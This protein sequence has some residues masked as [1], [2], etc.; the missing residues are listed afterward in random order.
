MKK[1]MQVAKKVPLKKKAKA[2]TKT[3][4]K[5]QPKA[6]KEDK[7]KKYNGGTKKIAEKL[8]FIIWCGLSTKEKK[9]LQTQ[10]DFAKEF[11]VNIATLSKWK[12]TKGFWEAVAKHRNNR[13]KERVGDALESMFEKRIEK[14]G[15][16]TAVKIFLQA[17]GEFTEVT[18]D[19]SEDPMTPEKQKQI[20]DAVTKWKNK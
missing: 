4:V 6:T 8:D 10:N 12:N 18:K 3:K 13:W 20:A 16:E 19:V 9:E 7:E 11:G 1:G 2:K 14:K 15:S 17:I 5:A